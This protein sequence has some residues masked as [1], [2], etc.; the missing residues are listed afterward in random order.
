A[1]L[2]KIIPTITPDNKPT[3]AN[4]IE[5]SY[6]SAKSIFS[7][8]SP[9]PA[10][11]PWP[12]SKAISIKAPDIDGIPKKGAKINAA[13]PTPTTY[14]PHPIVHPND[15]CGPA[16]RQIFLRPGMV[17]PRKREANTTLIINPGNDSH[18]SV[19]CS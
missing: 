3:V 9:I 10:A 5:R 2:I 6:P 13:R 15:N 7:K 16:N 12:P 4:P 17:E 8:V 14:C 1:Q 11:V 18:T 19:T